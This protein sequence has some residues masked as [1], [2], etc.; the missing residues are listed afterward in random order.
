MQLRHLEDARGEKVH[1]IGLEADV[2][3]SHQEVESVEGSR[4]RNDAH[5]GHD[6]RSGGQPAVVLY[7][8]PFGRELWLVLQ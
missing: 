7:R 5:S 4:C 1:E 6:D 8:V 2:W 3:G